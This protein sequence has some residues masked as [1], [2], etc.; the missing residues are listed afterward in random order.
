VP[1]AIAITLGHTMVAFS[2]VLCA[3]S[4]CWSTTSR[5]AIA[6]RAVPGLGATAAALAFANIAAAATLI[7][8]MGALTIGGERALP[9]LGAWAISTRGPRGRRAATQFLGG[10]LVLAVATWVGRVFAMLA[11]RRRGD[12]A[13]IDLVL[14]LFAIGRW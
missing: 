13:R 12:E 10:I 11:G 1:R 4:A 8:N 6:R 5:A 7:V 9:L 3:C 2:A 14:S